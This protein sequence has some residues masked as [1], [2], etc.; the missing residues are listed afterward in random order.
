MGLGC[1]NK[2]C[3]RVEYVD[4]QEF[5]DES[6]EGAALELGPLHVAAPSDGGTHG[7]G[8]QTWFIDSRG[9]PGRRQGRQEASGEGVQMLA[10]VDLR[11]QFE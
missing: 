7:R 1:G 5:R 3:G 8:S 11:G 9:D 6:D 2:W 4:L 10:S